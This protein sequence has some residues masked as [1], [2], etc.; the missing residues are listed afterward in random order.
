[1]ANGVIWVNVQLKTGG[2]CSVMKVPDPGFSG[3]IRRG[4]YFNAVYTIVPDGQG[5]ALHNGG[6]N[7]S[8]INGS[9]VYKTREFAKSEAE[10][11]WSD[12]WRE[13]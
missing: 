13:G 11:F 5:F 2:Y 7:G 3:G 9:Y 1:M 8:R 10:C 4:P 12:R 6:P